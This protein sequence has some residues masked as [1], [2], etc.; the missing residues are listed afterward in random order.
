MAEQPDRDDSRVKLTAV[1]AIAAPVIA[2]PVVLPLAAYA[3]IMET[4]ALTLVVAVIA[5][6]LAFIFALLTLV[7]RPTRLELWLAVLAVI[8]AAF[9]LYGWDVAT[10]YAIAHREKQS[11]RVNFTLSALEG[12]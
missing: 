10:D 3:V 5:A 6:S 1:L 11:S 2:A 8:A 9:L 12:V 4:A 7:R